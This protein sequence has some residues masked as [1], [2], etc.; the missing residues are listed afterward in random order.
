MSH[1]SRFLFE[2]LNSKF[3]LVQLS[4]NIFISS[5]PKPKSRFYLLI[6]ILIWSLKIS[7][8]HAQNPNYFAY[9]DEHGLPSNEVYSFI[10]DDEGII[11]IAGD[12][13]LYRFNGNEFLNFKTVEQKSR[14]L[15][16]LT[17][18]INK[19][20]FC[21][22]FIGQVFMTNKDSLVYLKREFQTINNIS[23]DKFGSLI[24][25][26]S[27]G[28]SIFNE[29]ENKWI[30]LPGFY[31]NAF[32]PKFKLTAKCT[33]NSQAKKVAFLNSNGIHVYNNGNI[34]SVYSELCKDISPGK[35][36]IEPFNNEYLIFSINQPQFFR[37]DG[38][39]IKTLNKSNLISALEGRKITKIKQLYD[40]N[41]W[42]CTYNG[43]LKVNLE[44]DKVQVYFPDLSFSDCFIDL[45]GNYW[46]S[47]LQSGILYIN[48]FNQSF[49]NKENPLIKNERITKVINAQ[50]NIYFA[51][52][53]GEIGQLNQQTNE[54]KLFSTNFKADVQNLDFD[55]KSKTVRLFINN[56][57]FNLKDS[58]LSRDK[59]EIPAVKTSMRVGEDVFYGT[60][61]GLYLLRNNELK[62]LRPGW[63]REIKYQE[64]NRKL[65]VA[66]NDGLCLFIKDENGKWHLKRNYLPQKQIL[67]IAISSDGNE[68]FAL[69]FNGVVYVINFSQNKAFELVQI[70]KN[71]QTKKIVCSNEILYVATTKGVWTYNLKNKIVRVLNKYDGLVSKNVYDLT[72]DGKNLW[73]ATGKGL[74]RIEIGDNK[75]V[76]LAKINVTKVEIAGKRQSNLKKLSLN[77]GQLLKIYPDVM[78]FSSNGD[79]K[80]AYRLKNN[81]WNKYPASIGEIT[82]PN[83]PSGNFEIE[84]AAFDYLGRKSKNSVFLKGYVYPPVWERTWFYFLIA[85]VFV[86]VVFAISRYIIYN[87][88][89]KALIETELSDLKLTAIKAQ[90]NPHFI[91]NAL[92]SIQDLVLKGDVDNSYSSIIT[93]SKLVRKTLD[94]SGKS[95]V[96]F[97]QEIELIKLYLALEK[98]RFKSSLNIIL[99]IPSIENILIPPM[100]I[101]PFI[102]NSLLHG[103]LHKEGERILKISFQHNE[104]ELICVVEDN[105]IGRK[106]SQVIADRRGGKHIS[107]SGKAI[108]KRFEILNQT[109]TGKVGFFYEDLIENG[110][111][112]G[113]RVTISIPFIR[114]F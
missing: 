36:M 30:D 91:F 110:T 39:K 107:F 69:A 10:Q 50:N 86:F 13:G 109:S 66:F 44:K 40:G 102:E 4:E 88:Q 55:P 45:E 28:I 78:A 103:L 70:N 57:I 5:L 87:I 3:K 20:L 9:N 89:K 112:T 90:M 33:S 65:L 24:V 73:L 79:Y 113:T 68:I 8:S 81:V 32:E 25:S 23:S 19:K 53:I 108:E 84:I 60:S 43:I 34:K 80:L 37:F 22:N 93:F 98:L 49:W 64:V 85:V 61:S 74:Q 27:R 14:S 59:L 106:Q 58:K 18:S 41:L 101:Q 11:W 42:I 7:F 12:A 82:I 2:L 111:E 76:A 96:E 48:N 54:L 105:G 114:K 15:T 38:N 71:V 46:F 72:I 97:E 75:K 26:H 94:Y 56:L 6:A 99:N 95:H 52:S 29:N 31:E 63:S 35:F 67:S 51:N 47:T 16:G 104:N 83:I 62:I 77:N 21:Y 100:L 92:N 17:K 1:L